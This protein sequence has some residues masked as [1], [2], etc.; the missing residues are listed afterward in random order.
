MGRITIQR[1]LE[2]NEGNKISTFQIRQ[3][4]KKTYPSGVIAVELELS[5]LTGHMKSKLFT[6]DKQADKILSEMK[7]GDIYEIS[8]SYSFQYKSFTIGS[9]NKIHDFN[10]KDFVIIPDINADALMDEIY[11]IIEE[12]E[13][14]HLKKLCEIAFQDKELVEK[15]KK[16]P[17]AKKYHHAYPSG[18][19][20]HVVGVLRICKTLIDF[21]HDPKNPH[22]NKE[23]LFVGAIFHDIGKVFTYNEHNGV[24]TLT[25]EGSKIDHIV[26]GNNF[27]LQLINKLDDFPKELEI[28]LLHMILSHHGRIDWGSPVI[29]VTPEAELLHYADLLD[30]RFKKALEGKFE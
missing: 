9:L 21:Y 14:P 10:L 20:E 27:I 4:S 26:L 15:F 16:I 5:D 25:E 28:N 3:K 1:I 6:S 11:S 2:E 13:N 8:G 24:V 29:P 18:N 23:L 12:L 7:V 30:S 17:S 22:I 19:L